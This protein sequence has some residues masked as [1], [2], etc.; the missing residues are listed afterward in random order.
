MLLRGIDWLSTK[1][2]EFM[3]CGLRKRRREDDR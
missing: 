3:A 2:V 1:I